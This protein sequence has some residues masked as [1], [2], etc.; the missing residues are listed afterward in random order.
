MTLNLISGHSCFKLS[1]LISKRLKIP[2]IRL[3]GYISLNRRVEIISTE[4][5]KCDEILILGSP[6]IELQNVNDCLLEL[7][8][9][10]N[11]CKKISKAKITISKMKI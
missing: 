9:M 6:S 3:F 7:M 5:P 4:I 10:I 2:L 1:A 11:L 8:F